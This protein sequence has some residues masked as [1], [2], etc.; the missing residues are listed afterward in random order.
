MTSYE[1]LIK[2]NAAK[3]GEAI[4]NRDK[5]EVFFV[6]ILVNYSKATGVD[7][8]QAIE[9]KGTDMAKTLYANISNGN[10]NPEQGGKP[11]IADLEELP[12]EG[13]KSTVVPNTGYVENVYINTKLTKDEF[14]P[15]FEKLDYD[16]DDCYTALVTE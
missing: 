10:E 9:E 6:P 5:I 8:S 16:S 12:K 13:W 2:T 7:I 14:I 11:P 1:E 15:L 4:L 3:R